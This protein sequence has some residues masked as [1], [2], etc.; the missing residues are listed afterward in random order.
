MANCTSHVHPH[1]ANRWHYA[2]PV[3][4]GM[5]SI[6]PLPECERQGNELSALPRVAEECMRE[7]G[8]SEQGTWTVGAIRRARYCK[9]EWMTQEDTK[10]MFPVATKQLAVAQWRGQA[11]PHPHPG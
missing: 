9:G 8:G 7:T 3:E 4:A 11:L 2:F 10:V 5:E 1:T 6:A